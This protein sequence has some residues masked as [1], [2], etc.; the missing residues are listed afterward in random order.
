LATDNG[1]MIGAAAVH[2]LERGAIT[3]WESTVEAGKRL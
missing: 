3:S 1:A 2:W